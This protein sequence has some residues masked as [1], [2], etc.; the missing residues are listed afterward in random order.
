[1]LIEIQMIV[2]RFE[3]PDL[4]RLRKLA[5]QSD[6]LLENFQPGTLSKYGLDYENLAPSNPGLVHTSVLANSQIT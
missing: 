5:D 6:V 4:V 3:I 2:L 1:M